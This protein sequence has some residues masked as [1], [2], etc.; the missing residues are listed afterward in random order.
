MRGVGR[1]HDKAPPPAARREREVTALAAT[2]SHLE[3]LLAYY[4][5]VQGVGPDDYDVEPRWHAMAEAKYLAAIAAL[6]RTG[7]LAAVDHERRVEA[8]LDRLTSS[9]ASGAEA[10]T[11]WG[12]GFE[13]GAA[14]A[15]EPYTITTAQV[16]AGLVDNEVLL[17]EPAGRR[18]RATAA[19]AVRWLTEG[20]PRLQVHALELPV[21]SP[22]NSRLIHNATAY[23][24]YAL[25]AATDAG[26]AVTIDLVPIAEWLLEQK[27]GDVGWTYEAG[28]AR[29]DLLHTCYIV[30][31]LMA[32]IPPT[33]PRAAEVDRHALLACAQFVESNGLR[34]HFDVLQLS[35]VLAKPRPWNGRAF[36]LVGSWALS[37]LDTPARAWSVGEL[38][39]VAAAGSGRPAVGGLWQTQIRWLSAM[40]AEQHASCTS[41]R[42]A[43]HLA[44]GQ[45]RVLEVLRGT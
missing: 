7:L 10:G 9:T 40:A 12:L 41:L 17:E 19:E 37:G 2:R 23:W 14:G 26:H 24:I 21:Y 27:V 36:R 43:M 4:E 18:C 25:R 8:A 35:D 44:H 22:T 16:A 42:H 32:V 33:H 38:L 13:Y 15:D 20:C 28:S 31:A 45:A 11:A 6:R 29:A 3:S 34:D 30:L 39:V 1:D 5:R